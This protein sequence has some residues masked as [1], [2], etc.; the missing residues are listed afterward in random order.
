VRVREEG[1]RVGC[2]QLEMAGAGTASACV[3]GAESTA[4]TRTVRGDRSDGRGPLRREKTGRAREGKR[5]R[6]VGPTGYRE[7][8]SG[9][10][11]RG[12]TLTCRVCMSVGGWAHGAGPS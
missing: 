6:Q 11:R 8:G 12:L 9:D 1:E 2:G 4:C 7:R 3:V 10:A 5:R